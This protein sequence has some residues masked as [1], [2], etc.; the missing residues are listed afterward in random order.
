MRYGCPVVVN[1]I[2]VFKEIFGHKAIYFNDSDSLT[3]SLVEILVNQ[4][5]IDDLKENCINLAKKFKWE[6]T[7]KKTIEVYKLI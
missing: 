3:H 5:N 4:R 6:D 1:D 2:K 7:T